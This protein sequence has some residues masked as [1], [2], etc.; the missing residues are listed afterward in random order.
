MSRITAQIRDIEAKHGMRAI[1]L[2]EHVRRLSPCT[3]DMLVTTDRHP[4]LKCR[5]D[6][7]LA[8]VFELLDTDPRRGA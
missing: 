4:C 3:C 1:V 5:C 8:E 6:R 2:A 7:F